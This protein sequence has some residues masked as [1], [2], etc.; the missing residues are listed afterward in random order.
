[1]LLINLHTIHVHQTQSKEK[2]E[3]EITKEFK[4][5]TS[6]VKEN[7]E[8]IFI[9]ASLQEDLTEWYHQNLKHPGGDRMYLIIKE[10]FY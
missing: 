5:I 8:Q 3:N 7:T 1:M 9:P 6:K 2:Y 10:T 4:D